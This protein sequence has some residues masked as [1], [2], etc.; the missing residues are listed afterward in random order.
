MMDENRDE[1]CDDALLLDAVRKTMAATPYCMLVTVGNSGDLEARMMDTLEPEA[2]MSIW[3]GTSPTTRK[4]RQLE[5]DSRA[6]LT[7]CD[8]SGF[9]Y[10]TMIGRARLVLDLD[11]RQRRWKNEWVDF[12]PDG[13]AGDGFA[14]LEF[15]PERIEAMSVAHELGVGPFEPACLVRA[16]AGWVSGRPPDA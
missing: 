11:E 13:P 5:V 14:L 12:Y 10:V 9:G 6:T 3:M 8:D 16:G 7:F 4:V 15:T 2:D 1:P